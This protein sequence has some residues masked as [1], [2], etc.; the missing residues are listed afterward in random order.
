VQDFVEKSHYYE[1]EMARDPRWKLSHEKFTFLNSDAGLQDAISILEC[2]F[3]KWG[4]EN[5]LAFVR[6]GS[7][8]FDPDKPGDWRQ[9]CNF[10][11]VAGAHVPGSNKRAFNI[12]EYLRCIKSGMRYIYENPDVWHNGS[13]PDIPC[14][15][16]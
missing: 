12:C 4:I 9:Q 15:H 2:A 11:G 1:E 13:R 5:T 10:V 6:Q 16:I 14:R 7:E 3:A 8:G